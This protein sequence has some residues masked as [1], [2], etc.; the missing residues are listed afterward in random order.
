MN[1]K[2]TLVMGIVF[3]GVLATVAMLKSM[4]TLTDAERAVRRDKVIP[5]LHDVDPDNLTQVALT[6]DKEQ[7][8]FNY[9]E[10]GD[11]WQMTKPLDVLA[12]TSAVRDLF[13]DLKNLA[14]RDSAAKKDEKAGVFTP[15]SQSD[16]VEYGLD[17][18]SS[19]ITV[20]FKP[21]GSDKAKSVTL[22]IG[23]A[24]ADKEGLYV[25]LPT[26]KVVFVVNK[27]N[28]R[29]L[30][31]K[32]NDFRQQKLI[33]VGRFD[34]DMV[35]FEWLDRVVG[36]EKQDA[37]WHLVDP[38][39]DRADAN[40][41]EELIG[42]LGE[43]KADGDADYIEDAPADLSKY[44]LDTPQLVAEIRKPGSKPKT[45]D[46]KKSKEKEK[47]TIVE[48]VLIGKPVEG[49][50]DK[51]Y[52]KLADQ[53]YVIAVAANTVKDLEKQ[54][55]ELRSHDLVEVTQA[56]VD[57]VRLHSERSGTEV[58]LAKKDF[59]W[60]IVQ[61]KT[62]KAEQAAVTE[63]VRKI[64]DLDIKEFLDQGDRSE[65]GLE[66][67]A[68][69]VAIWQKGLKADDKE[70]RDKAKKD[71]K[72]EQKKDETS[73]ASEPK[74]EPIRV[75]FGKV[76]DEKK[77]VYVRRG[78]DATIFGVSS[79]GLMDIVDR[80]YLAYR[81]KQVLSFNQS[82]VA[83]LVI[84]R[85]GKTFG[86]EHK[87]QKEDDIQETWRLIDPVDAPADSNTISKILGSF[88]RLNA[89]KF[90]TEEGADLKV[91]GLEEPR[92]RATAT[93]KQVGDKE[94]EQH[95]LL[96]GNES[97]DGGYYAKLGADNLIFS[98]DR[99]L[100]DDLNSELRDHTVLK[101]DSFKVDGLTLTWADGKTL[102]LAYKKPEEQTTIKAWSVVND[103]EFKL[104]TRKV[105]ELVSQLAMLNADRF[106][107][108]D[109]DFTEAQGLLQPALL[110]EVTLEGESTPKTLRIGAA[111]GD[112]RNVTTG[113][114][115]GPVALVPE[116]R[117]KDVLTGPAHFAQPEEKKPDSETPEPAKSED[118]K[119]SKTAPTDEK[120]T[121]EKKT[122]AKK[123]EEKPDEN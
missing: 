11:R 90:I 99:P 89:K 45:D 62:I 17:S 94:S 83:K 70:A 86:A 77:L 80:N 6:R 27:S 110:I 91:Y 92:I 63:L 29:S 22:Q 75:S 66:Q 13:F 121:D 1:P 15:K 113:E 105:T 53:K 72:N 18:P 102:E 37:K 10:S 32:A 79:E 108:Y 59:D 98:V 12:Q 14:R 40:K 31:K 44:G 100:I 120:K 95:V 85:D 106:S 42:K 4:H 96:V 46:K 3:V 52:A 114:K 43:L 38:V 39:A 57:Y 54:P 112:R 93:L 87:K 49:R 103:D 74:G 69:T 8:E 28:L 104:D 122:D 88:S 47:P 111:E 64:D 119:E 81:R 65:Y 115:S 23:S 117:F 67:P 5:E 118:N 41:V 84:R 20:T 19:S 58:A 9:V 48:K 21:K 76:D 97:E 51:V 109:G 68:V 24:T 71:Q 36:A 107:Q 55:N 2:T 30:E 33:T 7:F 61:P 82:D 73:S 78:D 60:E 50:E 16:L 123:D 34:S 35:R 101:F 116:D 25:K 56:D 26:E